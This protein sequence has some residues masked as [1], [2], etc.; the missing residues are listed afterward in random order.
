[1][2]MLSAEIPMIADDGNAHLQRLLAASPLSYRAASWSHQSSAYYYTDLYA[3]VR[4]VNWRLE[5]E[6]PREEA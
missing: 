1:M 5:V 2:V 4:I 3:D 6:H